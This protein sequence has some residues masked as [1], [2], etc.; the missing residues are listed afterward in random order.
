MEGEPP[1]RLFDVA[2]AIAEN[3]HL[4]ALAW[5]LWWQIFRSPTWA[6]PANQAWPALTKS[7]GG[8]GGVFYLIITMNLHRL[9]EEVHPR[10]GFSKEVT[11]STSLQFSCVAHNHQRG[12]GRLGVYP[13][14]LGWFRNYV[15]EP[16]VRIGRLE[17]WYKGYVGGVHVFRNG[18]TREAIALAEDGQLFDELGRAAAPDSVPGVAGCWKAGL[19]RDGDGV[20]GHRIAPGGR[21]ELSET[22]LALT[23]WSCV[24]EKG[25]PVLELHIPAGGGLS[26]E[27][28]TESF[29]QAQAFFKPLYPLAPPVAIATASWMFSPDLPEILPEGSN[30]LKIQ[31]HIGLY[32][33]PA[34]GNGALWFVFQ[35]EPL[36]LATAPRETSLQRAL[37]AWLEAGNPWRSG[38][39]Y[40]LL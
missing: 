16:Y 21:V 12:T 32:P 26:P 7:L 2:Q 31:K 22:R 1:T 14:Q 29:S 5:H 28:M 37:L 3:E 11:R 24:L 18:G 35:R 6:R 10:W 25:A 34:G 38:G 19:V 39:M 30:L 15:R 13:Q 8:D 40:Y 36:D 33:I 23:E 9:L 17:Y 27:L 20:R 4:S